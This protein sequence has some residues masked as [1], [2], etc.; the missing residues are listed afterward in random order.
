MH[1][2]IRK[3]RIRK[4]IYILV[5]FALI[6]CGVFVLFEKK[7]VFEVSEIL[8]RVVINDDGQKLVFENIES[9]NV[10]KVL[11][12]LNFDLREGD[13]IFP[14]KE[15]QVF[16]GDI[17]NIER[18]KTLT[19]K[20]DGE[21]KEFKTYGETIGELLARN[22]VAFDDNDIVKPS[23]Q[24]LVQRDVEANIIRVEFKE[25][26]KVK[27]IPFKKIT[28][29]DD[30]LS[31]LKKYIK[32]KG[33]SGKKKIIYKVA[34][35]D[36]KEVEREVDREEIIKEPIDEITVKGTKV[37]LGK[38][39]TGKC[40]WYAY[41]GTM[42]AANPWL[43]KGSYVKVTNRANGKSVIV[44]INDRGPFVPGRII[45]LDKVAFEKIASLGAGVIDV[46]MEEIVE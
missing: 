13:R 21:K 36:G 11:N 43:P 22:Q 33:V 37:K 45:D 3:K 38:K 12:D 20:V 28:K 46:K 31:F 16:S 8:D 14:H 27:T 34:Y 23:L 25:E 5:I 26:T 2:R 30:D 40:S 10:E 32:Q 19:L 17:I 39:H 42:S 24:T 15:R 41:T 1:P 44:Q 4:F 7:H 35:H 6:G 9:G 29:E 18:Q